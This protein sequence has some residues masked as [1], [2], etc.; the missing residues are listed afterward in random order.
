LLE[1]QTS[2]KASPTTPKITKLTLLKKE[3]I[4]S[5]SNSGNEA[6]DCVTW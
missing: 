5:M 1:L 2:S 3:V 4:N 6:V